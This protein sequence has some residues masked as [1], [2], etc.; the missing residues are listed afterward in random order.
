VLLSLEGEA[1]LTVV[2]NRT[3]APV[4]VARFIETVRFGSYTNASI[5][6][7]DEDLT[8]FGNRW[9]N[10]EGVW[11]RFSRDEP[12]TTV[13]PMSVT[14][15]G[16][17]PDTADGRVAIRWH[18]NPELDRRETVI[19]RG[20]LPRPPANSGDVL[21]ALQLGKLIRKIAVGGE[22]RLAPAGPGDPCNPR[23]PW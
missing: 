16:H 6:R 18:A 20:Y 9:A 4:A 14:L 5:Y 21:E 22:G 1:A 15:P 10:D 7:D 19:G 11:T 2:L 3:I 13:S 17:G 12:G 8:V 23:A